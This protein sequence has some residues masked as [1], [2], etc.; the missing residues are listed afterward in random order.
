MLPCISSQ[1]LR[2]YKLVQVVTLTS[3]H[4]AFMP[5]TPRMHSLQRERTAGGR[6]RQLAK[7]AGVWQRNAQAQD[8]CNSPSIC[9]R[10]GCHT[11]SPAEPVHAGCD[12]W[13][14][15]HIQADGAPADG[16]GSPLRW[17]SFGHHAGRL[18]LASC[19]WKKGRS[20]RCLP[21]TPHRAPPASGRWA[22]AHPPRQPPGGGVAVQRP[23]RTSDR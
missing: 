10:S 23:P 22:P 7:C 13:A 19:L 8:L 6:V 14:L 21:L 12:R 5:S 4:L 20:P 17:Q 3:G 11:H 1:A 16:V 15:Q 18:P 9:N 2:L